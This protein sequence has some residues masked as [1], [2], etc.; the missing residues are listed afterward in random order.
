MVSFNTCFL[1]AFIALLDNYERETGRAEQVTK[2]EEAENRHFI[3]EIIQTE[4]MKIAHDFLVSQD[5]APREELP[6]KKMLYYLWFKMYR[7]S[8]GT[9]C[10]TFC[11]TVL[12]LLFALRELV[13]LYARILTD[14][15]RI[16]IKLLYCIVLLNVKYGKQKALE[17]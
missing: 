15:N 5:L 14:L 2:K 12:A 16:Q 10:V 17:K 6:F 4:P 11:C 8:R 1:S 13:V 3:D 7:R 9:R